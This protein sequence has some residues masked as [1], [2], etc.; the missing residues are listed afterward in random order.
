[1]QYEDHIIEELVTC[2]APPVIVLAVK[3]EL[4][5]ILT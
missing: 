5:N 4:L 2:K 1:M 3:H